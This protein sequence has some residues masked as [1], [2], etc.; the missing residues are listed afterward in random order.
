MLSAQLPARR[1]R[2]FLGDLAVL[3]W[4]A[5]WVAFARWLHDQ[6]LRL[7]GPGRSLEDGGRGLAA[8]L[9]DAGN[10]VGSI[11]FAGRALRAPFSAAGD[12]GRALQ[13]AGAAQQDAVTQAAIYVPLAIVAIPI[14]YVVLRRVVSRWRWM[15][16]ATAAARIRSDGADL[17]LFALRA[18]ARQPMPVLRGV[19]PDPVASWRRGD[20]E[21][22]RA[23]AQLELRELGLRVR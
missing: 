19:A 16:Q 21:T 11:P 7:A 13:H 2:Q 6:V 1:T 22:V 9:D 15:R 4:V 8:S 5:G 23:L 14:L 20:V 10:R 12:A 18:L 3:A 17:D